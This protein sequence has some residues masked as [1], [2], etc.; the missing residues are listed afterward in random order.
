MPIKVKCECG[1]RINVLDDHAGRQ[2]RCPSCMSM[3]AVPGEADDEAGY[4]TEQVRK[5]PGCKR[6]WPVDTALCID[7]GY[8]FETGRKMRT[9]YNIPDRV[10]DLGVTWLGCYTRYSVFRSSQGKPCLSISQKLFFL[11]LGTTTH[12]LSGYD[13]ILTDFTPGDDEGGDTLH[14][15]LQGRGKRDVT[16]FSSSNEQVMKELIDLVSQAGRLEIKRK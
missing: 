6:E 12:D 2:V 11:P 16:I 7:C 3:V 5:C 8:N 4:A 14:L 9:K 15:E 1:K 10:V 13:A